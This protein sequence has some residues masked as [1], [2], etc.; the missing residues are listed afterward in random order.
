MEAATSGRL[1]TKRV[2]N[3]AGRVVLIGLL[4]FS[5]QQIGPQRAALTWTGWSLE[6][7]LSNAFQSE[8]PEPFYT[9]Q[10]FIEM[11]LN[12]RITQRGVYSGFSAAW[13]KTGAQLLYGPSLVKVMKNEWNGQL[14][15]CTW[16]ERLSGSG[17]GLDNTRAFVFE[18]NAL[19]NHLWKKKTRVY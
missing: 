19:I 5:L 18:G 2:F 8:T 1:I 15:D 16:D 3:S 11:K 17:W 6:R 9:T 10:D 12:G 4:S 14:W 7:C 13:K